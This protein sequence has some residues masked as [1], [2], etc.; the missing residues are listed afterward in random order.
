MNIDICRSSEDVFEKH[1][2]LL[3]PDAEK[4]VQS[5]KENSAANDLGIF[6][7]IKKEKRRKEELGPVIPNQLPEVAMKYRSEEYKISVVVNKILDGLKIPTN[8]SGIRV[9]ILNEAVAKK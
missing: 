7:E 3:V 1:I 8:C 9:P 6:E 5:G 4:Q 2:N